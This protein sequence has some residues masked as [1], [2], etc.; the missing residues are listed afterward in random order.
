[1]TE[2]SNETPAQSGPAQAQPGVPPQGLT[3][4]DLR[5]IISIIETC[6]DR[7]SFQA[8]EMVAVGATYNK[9]VAFVTSQTPAPNAELKQQPPTD[10]EPAPE[11][12]PEP[13]LE[14]RTQQSVEN[15]TVEQAATIPN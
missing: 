11:P 5:V 7:G 12:L 10:P 4:N 9:L 1:M 13:A 14:A 6:A 15:E 3:L 2:I 8:A